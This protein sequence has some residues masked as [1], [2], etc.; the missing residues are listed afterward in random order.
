MLEAGGAEAQRI[1][2]AEPLLAARGVAEGFARMMFVPGEN[3]LLQVLGVDQ[4]TGPAGDL[5]RLDFPAF[6][7]AWVVGRPG[8]FLLF[9]FAVA[10]LAVL[11]GLATIALRRMPRRGR[12][13]DADPVPHG[14]IERTEA[15]PRFRVPIV[16]LLAMLAGMGWQDLQS[17]FARARPG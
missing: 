10:H 11:Y 4:P 15:Y 12:S 9:V 5:M 2:R 3:A 7:R 17:A 14:A 16:P 1:L 6:L 8:Q 13:S